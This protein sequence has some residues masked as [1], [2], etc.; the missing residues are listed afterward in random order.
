MKAQ[1]GKMSSKLMVNL[2][3]ARGACEYVLHSL[4]VEAANWD[5]YLEKKGTFEDAY[6]KAYQ[7]LA[8]TMKGKS[9]DQ[10]AS[11]AMA[12]AK[13][14][15]PGLQNETDVCVYEESRPKARQKHEASKTMHGH[16]SGFN[17]DYDL[18][19]R[20]LEVAREKKCGNC[21][22]MAGLAFT[23][24]LSYINARSQQ[25][26]LANPTKLYWFE[27]KLGEIDDHSICVIDCEKPQSTVPSSWGPDAVVC[28][29]WMYG[30]MKLKNGGK[31]SPD[32]EGAKGFRARELPDYLDKAFGFHDMKN[33]SMRGQATPKF[34]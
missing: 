16:K 22:E 34:N 29:P 9:P 26:C 4:G 25:I 21:G 30:F 13:K 24:L 17:E 12:M 14:L 31:P 23:H 27:F 1:G 20:Q 3:L 19:Q 18:S 33:F 5:Y 10:I 8:I 2:Q 6:W 32:T 15:N 7:G 11:A 28:D